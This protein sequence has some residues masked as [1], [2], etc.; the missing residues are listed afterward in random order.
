[1]LKERIQ[2]A[3]HN[4]QRAHNH[5]R[6]EDEALKDNSQREFKERLVGRGTLEA[7]DVMIKEAHQDNQILSKSS[8]PTLEP[9]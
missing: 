3:N 7:A 2:S 4:A 9:R 5:Q 6:W 8:E 1:M